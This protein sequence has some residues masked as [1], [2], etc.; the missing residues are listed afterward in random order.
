MRNKRL[1]KIT[2][3]TAIILG[4]LIYPLISHSQ[5]TFSQVAKEN[6]VPVSFVALIASP[7]EDRDKAYN[8]I[9]ENWE[10]SFPVMMI[11]A[12]YLNSDPSFTAK[13][14]T[15]LEEKTG[16][17]YG[18]EL[19]K[20]YEWIWSKEEM[21]HPQYPEFKSLLYSLIDP[22][23]KGYF[24][25][26]RT[27]K[28]RLDEVRW[29]G[30]R[31]DGIPPLRNPNM[32]PAKEAKYLD[33]DNIVFGI[34]VNGDARAYPKR[35]MAWH[36]MFVDTVGGEKVAGVYCT[37]CGSM[38]LYN[39]VHDGKNH[40]IGTSGFLYRSNKLMY[41]KET[42][43]LW[44]TLWG[45][46]V[47]G[48]LADKEIELERMSIVTT[49]WGEW[50]KRHPD[51]KVLS[52]DT[53][54]RRDYSEGA[55]YRDYFATDELMFNVPKLDKRLKNKDEVLGLIFSQYPDK[56]LAI[57]IG[58]LS[59]N[60]L[61][62]KKIGNL[63][64]IVL[65]DK[66]GASRVYETKGTKFKSWDQKSTVTDGN[67]TKWVLSEDKLIS[68]DGKELYRLPAHRAFWFGWY[69]AYSNTELIL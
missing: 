36:E 34:E 29:G 42:Q 39:T 22:K 46:P 43:S 51:T 12:I 41:D 8:Y 50:K 7:P 28:I 35:I 15:L 64:F 44:N 17:S 38:I 55:A 24:S 54:H 5:E 26:N 13:L 68:A 6:L 33:N 62:E 16:Q 21:A 53:G 65:T 67:G 30:V 66:S 60:P 61:Y 25:S 45:K 19:D 31:Q 11:E 59:K 48:P 2:L 14:V 18:Y 56:P 9:S 37:L 49:T 27:N 10:S 1:T 47:I 63:D 3:L 32:I 69:G 4:L 57:S 20:W 23:F 58:Y 40:E 52:L